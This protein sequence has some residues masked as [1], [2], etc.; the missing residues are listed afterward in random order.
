MHQFVCLSLSQRDIFFSFSSNVC[1]NLTHVFLILYVMLLESFGFLAY[2]PFECSLNLTIL[3][4]KW[5]RNAFSSFE[6]IVTRYFLFI[7]LR[8]IILV[9]EFSLY[10]TFPRYGT[11]HFCF[12]VIGPPFVKISNGVFESLIFVMYF[13]LQ[14]TVSVESLS[15][16]IKSFKFAVCANDTCI[17][18]HPSCACSFF[19]VILLSLLNDPLYA[20]LCSFFTL[21]CCWALFITHSSPGIFFF[22]R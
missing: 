17:P 22:L 4:G 5:T 18:D 6:S 16:R 7:S 13:E 20:S 12:V 2:K 8:L 10:H 21:A 1:S 15:N 11:V 9:I 3:F 19:V 14:N